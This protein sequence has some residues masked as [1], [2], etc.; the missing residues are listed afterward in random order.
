[1]LP[2]AEHLQHCKEQAFKALSWGELQEAQD[3]MCRGILQHPGTQ[4]LAYVGLWG[5][6]ATQAGELETPGE[7]YDWIE[8]QYKL[9]Q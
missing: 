1:V 6:T 3:I 8:S 4:H 5:L 2:A 7:L 9:A